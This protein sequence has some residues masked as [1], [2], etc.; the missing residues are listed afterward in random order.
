MKM[1]DG[2][3]KKLKPWRWI[4]WLRNRG[5]L[6]KL[7]AWARGTVG[8]LLQAECKPDCG[9]VGLWARSV[10]A[11]G[12]GNKEQRSARFTRCTRRIRFEVKAKLKGYVAGNGEVD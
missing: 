7:S 10:E 4:A 9:S 5:E 11:C 12:N 1:S 6:R 8:K 2:W 3:L